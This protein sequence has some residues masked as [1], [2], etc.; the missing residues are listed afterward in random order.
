MPFPTFRTFVGVAK[1]SINAQLSAATDVGA[2]SLPLQNTV[3]TTGTLTTSGATYSAI[4]FDGANTEVVACSGNLTG[5][6]IA[7]AAT[8]NKH[9]VNCYVAF[10]LTAS[11]GPTD[12]IPIESFQPNDVI[13][14]L[15]DK[16]LRGYSAETYGVQPGD[17]HGDWTIAGTVFPDTF[18]YILGAHFGADA[19]TGAGPYTHK[20]SVN[21]AGTYQP[22]HWLLY[23]LNGYNC[24]VFA[25]SFCSEV[26]IT[27]EPNQLV[28]YTS[29]WLTRAS[30]VLTTPNQSYSTV[31]PMPAWLA[32]VTLNG[33]TIG[34][35]TH[36][37]ATFT[38][39]QSEAV[40]ALTGN[41]DPST[42]FGGPQ[43]AKGKFT[44]IKADD[45][46][47]Q[48]YLGATPLT[49]PALSVALSAGSGGSATGLTLQWSQIAVTNVVPKLQ[50]QAL[51]E[52][53]CEFEGVANSTDG[54]PGTGSAPGQVQIVNAH[55][56]SSQY[57]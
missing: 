50:G 52:E 38:R 5:G 11:I 21:N 32:A 33:T 53:D 4:I 1:D 23:E 44:I 43:T 49:Q 40:P 39:A 16:S 34:N 18:G 24:R 25:G 17:R 27:L 20:F 22:S 6:A 2:T 56:S 30:G 9:S 15:I 37:E 14:Q 3:G 46:V 36:L 12:F 13:T 47:L 51:V 26:S 45:S 54:A 7:C 31:T 29:K 41:Q 57:V 48:F 19:V 8:A 42:L 35:A 55:S 28:K 10:Q